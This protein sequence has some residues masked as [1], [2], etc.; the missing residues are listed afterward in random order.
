M[1]RKTESCSQAAKKRMNDFDYK[2]LN[3][4]K[5]QVGDKVGVLQVVTVGWRGHYRHMY[6]KPEVIKR[7]SPKR[8]KF[9]TESGQE[10]SEDTTFVAMDAYA[11]SENEFV[12]R[13]RETRTAFN[14]FGSM[15]SEILAELPDDK[16][17][18]VARHL[19]AV[20]EILEETKKT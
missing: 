2:R 19:S 20:M 14:K 1:N 12:K 8:T 17:E 16:L 9:C 13:L 18:L 5:I 7:I 4:D 6:A 3:P 10:Y 11:V 15:S